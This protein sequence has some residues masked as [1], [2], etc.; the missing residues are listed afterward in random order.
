M[1]NRLAGDSDL[2]EYFPNISAR[3]NAR[4]KEY[5]GKFNL[6]ITPY[7]L[8]LIK[9]D[10]NLNPAA[11]D[12]VWKQFK[13]LS[14]REL[15]GNCGYDAVHVNWELSSEM[16]TPILHHKYPGR[17]LLR[18]VNSCH[19]YCSYCYLTKRTLDVTEKRHFCFSGAV[20]RKS[21]AY[22]RG[23]PEISDVLISGGDPLVLPNK[24]LAKVLSEVSAIPS[25][26][27]IRLNTRVLT[28]NPYRIDNE[29]V[30]ILKRYRVNVLEIHLSHPNEITEA[31][32]RALAKFDENGYR[33]EILWRSPLLKGINDSKAVLKKLLLELYSRRIVPYYL[34]HCAPY[35]LARKYYGT[36]IERGIRLLKSLRREIPGPCFPRYTLFHSTGKQDIPQDTSG[37]KEFIFA[38][39]RQQPPYVKFLNWRGRWV[40]YP[41]I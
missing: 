21:L 32:D 19:G 37:T 8:S 25:V 2:T 11:G 31:F 41:D 10:A 36:S 17:A 24:S 9:L 13:Y 28:F 14:R 27:T 35:S 29:L 40:T 38:R 7:T 4:F 26:K 18:V 12:P 1:R 34:F 23:R 33:P 3:E 20:W 39:G 30:A 6:G 16:P 22:L 15:A 5:A